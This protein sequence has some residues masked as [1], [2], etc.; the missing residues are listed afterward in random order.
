MRKGSES[1]TAIWVAA[2]RGLAAFDR[3]VVSRDPVAKQLVPWPWRAALEVAEH[4]PRTTRAMLGLA[5]LASGGLSRHVPFRTRAIDDAVQEE[6]ARGTRQLVLLGAGLDGRAH[7]LEALAQ[8]TVFEI[9][10]PS[11]QARKRQAASSLRS[12]AR[13]IRYVPVDLTTGDLGAALGRA[14]HASGERTVFVWEG[15]TMYLQRPAIEATLAALARLAAPGSC[16]LVTYYCTDPPPLAPLVQPFFALVGEPLLTRL[17][18]GQMRALLGAHGFALD[19]D[20]G[21]DEWGERFT[22]HR[23]RW[24]MSERLARARRA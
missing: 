21:A 20:E 14:G 5:N 22:R 12:C 8:S 1:R 2:W 4:L 17:A 10:H 18:P 16:L 3:P 24:N 11:S 23:P 9:D 15:V 19:S 6:H 13:E 7:R